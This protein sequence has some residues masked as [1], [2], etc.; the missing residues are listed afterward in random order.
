MSG[1]KHELARLQTFARDYCRD[2]GDEDAADRLRLTLDDSTQRIIFSNLDGN[3]CGS[4]ISGFLN[5]ARQDETIVRSLS[6]ILRQRARERM[7]EASG[8]TGTPAWSIDIHRTTRMVLYNAGVN[9]LLLIEMHRRRQDSP[10][11]LEE[12][13]TAS[14]IHMTPERRGGRIVACA[15]AVESGRDMDDRLTLFDDDS[16][17]RTTC[18]MVRGMNLPA[19]AIAMHVGRPL[20]NLLDHPLLENAGDIMIS[21]IVNDGTALVIMLPDER[22][23]LSPLPTGLKADWLDFPWEP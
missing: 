22:V 23:T 10:T 17:Y 9:P 16:K 7:I 5:P 15:I 8:E 12:A 4:S 21:D 14:P 11:T 18:L 6:R 13:I 3:T 20:G 1:M 2:L 19:T